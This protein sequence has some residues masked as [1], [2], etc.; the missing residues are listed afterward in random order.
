MTGSGLMDFLIAIVGLCLIVGLIFIALDKIAPDE[1][2]KRIGRYAV[3]GVALIMFLLAI[4]GVLFGGGGAL[5]VTPVGLIEFAI[6]LVVLM[7]VL[8]LI[9]Y[10][11]DFLAPGN[12]TMPIKY[13]IGALALIALLVLAEQALT[14]GGLMGQHRA[15]QT[16]LSR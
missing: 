9:Y 13:V 10:A 15:P 14:G 8:F 12:F 2:F 1:Q 5:G 11:V 4:K 16:Q 6:G 7:V 3:G